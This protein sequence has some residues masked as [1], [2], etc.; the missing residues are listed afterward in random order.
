MSSRRAGRPLAIIVGDRPGDHVARRELVD[1]ALAVRVQERG[2]LTADR[3]GDQEP[4]AALDAGDRGRVELDEL[5]VGERRARRRGRAASR[6]RSIPAGWWCA[7][8]VRRRRRWQDHRAGAD[9]AAVLAD[10]ADAAALRTDRVAARAPSR[11]RH[12]ARL[13]T[14]AESW[15]TMRRPVALPPAWTTRR[16][17][18]RPP[19]RGPARR[20]GRRRSAR[21]AARDRRRGR[22][23]PAQHGRGARR[24]VSRPAPRCRRGAGRVSRRAASAAA[25]PPCA[26]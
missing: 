10:D 16:A 18:A 3:L 15:R 13:A 8:T 23:L 12:D 7:T 20:D 4:L 24:T 9:R 26:Q 22:R 21:R 11:D 25:R 5:Q 1:E 19:G 6:C 17:S 14:T 2:A